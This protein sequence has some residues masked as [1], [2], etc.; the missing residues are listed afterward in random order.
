MLINLFGKKLFFVVA[1]PDDESFF[2][3]GTIYQNSKRGGQSFIA[4]ATK[5]EKGKGHLQIKV[6]MAKLKQ[7]RKKELQNVSK[8]LRANKLFI[9]DFPDTK[10]NKH[11][12]EFKNKLK[13]LLNKLRP[14]FIIGFG[15]DG[16]T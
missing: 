10:L 13:L 7:I 9:F 14:D 12:N 5:G 16:M 1:H 4:C 8:F 11:Q 6:P 2:A 15:P 3:A